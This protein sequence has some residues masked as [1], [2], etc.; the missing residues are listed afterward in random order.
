MDIQK[1]P[2]AVFV[3]IGA[4]IVTA[5]FFLLY[6]LSGGECEEGVCDRLNPDGLIPL[7]PFPYGRESV[8][9]HVDVQDENTTMRGEM[10]IQPPRLA[11][12][13]EGDVLDF[14]IQVRLVNDG[15]ASYVWS[16]ALGE[17]ITGIPDTFGGIPGKTLVMSTLYGRSPEGVLEYFSDWEGVECEK[18]GEPPVGIFEPPEEAL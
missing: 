9:C 17:W 14:P 8:F 10:W 4:L 13:A 7:E 3:M 12:E 1:P 6:P 16:S 18:R 2:T 15:N 5:S 11:F